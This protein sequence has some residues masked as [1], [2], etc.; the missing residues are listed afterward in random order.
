MDQT[1]VL[2]AGAGP[3]G[4]LTALLLAKNG[5]QTAV[6]DQESRTAGHSYCCALHPRSLEILKRAGIVEDAIDFG[7]RID[8][9]AFYEGAKRQAE[10]KISKLPVEYPFV[11]VIEQCALE[12]LL[13][14]QLRKAG[15]RVNWDHRLAELEMEGQ[16]ATAVINTLAMTGKGY[17]VPDF[18][19]GV[20]RTSET[21]AQFVVGADGTN[22][23][24]RRQLDIAFDPAGPP[25]HY[26]V[27]EAETAGVLGHE[28]RVVMDNNA[29]SVFWPLSDTRCRWSFQITR[30]QPRD[31]FPE[32]DRNRMI[33]VETMAEVDGLRQLAR[34]R[35]PWFD[36]ALRE[37]VW[38]TDV[39]FEPRLARHFGR[40]Q[41]WLVGDAAHQTGPAGMQSMNMG[42]REAADLADN[43]AEILHKGGS[44]ELL[45]GYERAHREEWQQ[46]LNFRPEVPL[47]EKD[48]GWVERRAA[49]ILGCTPATGEELSQLLK[50][51][52]I[53]FHLTAAAENLAAGGRSVL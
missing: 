5:V 48:A 50:P 27:Y 25:Q 24:V 39:Q 31:D 45:K 6:I 41:A 19:L 53:Q 43:L 23:M 37:I 49:R 46:M 11:L 22:S 7:R 18:D 16:G 14:Q 21:R 9:V 30:V 47:P 52:G 4:M 40:K 51:M 35:A 2:V 8:T 36:H 34:H 13:E 1:E 26:A 15:V 32:K 29:T 12:N 17:G 20:K 3:V 10:T 44:R 28:V 42:F 33:I 38:A